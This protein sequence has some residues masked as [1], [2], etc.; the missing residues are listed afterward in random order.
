M[1]QIEN[2]YYSSI[3]P[4]AWRVPARAR[5]RRCGAAAWNTWRC[6]RWTVSA[7]DPVGVNQIKLRFLEAF[8]ALCLLRDSPPIDASEQDGSTTTT[9]R[10]RGAAASPD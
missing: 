8:A 5:A 2:E 4:S 6:A 10:S 9:C 7:F 1:L 3:R